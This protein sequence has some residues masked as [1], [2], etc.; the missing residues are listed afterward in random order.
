[1]SAYPSITAF[2]CDQSLGAH[3]G[4]AVP[5]QHDGAA[6]G[7]SPPPPPECLDAGSGAE[8]CPSGRRPRGAL[9][10]RCPLRRRRE[11]IRGTR[12]RRRKGEV[13][14]RGLK[15]E[16]GEEKREPGRRHPTWR[17]NAQP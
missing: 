1:M 15:E 13:N 9:P 8:R 2:A 14:E 3:G 17:V 5:A 4:Q 10:A 16:E 11:R 6:E 7:A 12:R